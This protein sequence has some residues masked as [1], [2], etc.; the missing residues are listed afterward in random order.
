MPRTRHTRRTSFPFSLALTGAAL[1]AAAPTAA[2]AKDLN[3][4]IGI[5]AEQSTGGLSSLS[6]RFGFP[7]G[8]PTL[9]IGLGAD[10][11]LDMRGATSGTAGSTDFY[12]GARLYFGVVAED[13][14]NLYFGATAGYASMEGADAIRVGPNLGAE[15]FLFG[16]ENLGFLAEMQ[17]NID[18]GGATRISTFGSPAVGFHYYF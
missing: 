3:G 17:L 9:N 15:F 11:G 16:L 10:A 14:M 6:V 1:L 4:R 13:N 7:T 18:I 2:F 8:A 5:G 12:A